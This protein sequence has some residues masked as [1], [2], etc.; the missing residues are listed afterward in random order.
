MN[1]CS[2]SDPISPTPSA[3]TAMKTP[4]PWSPGPSPSLTEN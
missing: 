1:H 3:S 4:D 2:V